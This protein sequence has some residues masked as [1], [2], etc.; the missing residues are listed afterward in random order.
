VLDRLART[1]RLLGD[2]AKSRAL[3]EESLVLFREIG[4]RTGLLCPLSTVAWDEWKQ[5]DRE[6]GM[7]LTADALALA[8][9]TGDTWWTA[10]ILHRLAVMA[11]DQ[12]D[13]TRAAALTRESV[14]LAYQL[15]NA[16]LLVWGIG[17]LAVLAAEAGEGAPAHEGRVSYVVPTPRWP[18]GPY[19]IVRSAPQRKHKTGPTNSV[20]LSSVAS[21]ARRRVGVLWGF[22]RNSDRRASGDHHTPQFVIRVASC[23]G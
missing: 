18:G 22:G 19:P 1:V 10:Y 2:H 8:R 7:Q 23:F 21:R 13:P 14:S 16:T 15:G 3:A 11:R 20:C 6:R 17:L 12:D 4:D 5:G 9:E